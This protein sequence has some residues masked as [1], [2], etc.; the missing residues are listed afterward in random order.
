MSTS[1]TVKPP[2]FNDI[3]FIYFDLDDT[4]IDHKKA[5]KRA[6][7]D[8]WTQFPQFQDGDPIH[9]TET[10]ARYNNLYWD[11]YRKN[12]IDQ[13]TLKRL[14]FEQTIKE[15]GVQGLDWREVET[16]YMDCYQ[17]HWDW[18]DDAREGFITLYGMYPVGIMT[19]G[20]IEVQQQKFEYFSLH[21][22][23]RHLIISE[24]V[25]HLKPDRRIFEYAAEKAGSR[26][27]QLLYVGDSHS[28]DILG[29]SQSG[30]KTAWY[31]QNEAEPASHIADFTF[32]HFSQLVQALS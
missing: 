16:I 15:L 20:F 10:Y 14:R 3:T 8:V 25:G 6:L 32:H 22:Y 27:D 5:Q 2:S 1:Q 23:S 29:G 18:I 31:T 30:W 17:R 19:N 21:R 24:E 7:L 9:L 12:E 4:L 11:A 26:P 13:P 28:S